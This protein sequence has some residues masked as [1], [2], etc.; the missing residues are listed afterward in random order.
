MQR[1]RTSLHTAAECDSTGMLCK[2]LV[3]RGATVNIRDKDGKTPLHLASERGLINNVRVLIQ[4]G[5]YINDQTDKVSRLT[6]VFL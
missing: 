4:Y 5:A 3:D 2:S 6:N 1:G